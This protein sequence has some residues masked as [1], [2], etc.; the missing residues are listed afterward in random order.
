M[1]SRGRKQLRWL[2]AA[3]EDVDEIIE[4]IAGRAPRTAEQFADRLFSKVEM[5]AQFPHLGSI[6]PHYRKARQ[7]IFGNFVIYYTVHR[8]EVVVRAVVRGARLFRS[9]W[10]KRED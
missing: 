10:L 6:C 7:L 4:H 9:W 3:L 1:T 2:R 8:Q 5:L